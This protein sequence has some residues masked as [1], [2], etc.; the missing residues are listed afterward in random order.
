MPNAT[1]R[2]NARS[3]PE[4]DATHRANPDRYW[5]E[6]HSN[7]EEQIRNLRCMSSI[8]EDFSCRITIEHDDLTF[9]AMTMTKRELDCLMCSVSTVSRMA[10]DL[11]KVYQAQVAPSRN[12]EPANV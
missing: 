3:M 11:D 12:E 1:V 8:A 9:V 6:A 4:A 7:L 2:A 10:D 5:R